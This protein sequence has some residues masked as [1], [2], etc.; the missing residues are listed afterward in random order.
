M[1]R[2]FNFFKKQT[3]D[4]KTG[5]IEF[6]VSN[7]GLYVYTTR[8]HI[9]VESRTRLWSD[10]GPNRNHIRPD[11]IDTLIE[12]LDKA[13]KVYNNNVHVYKEL[14][15]LELK[16]EL[17]TLQGYT[18]PEIVPPKLEAFYEDKIR[19]FV[20]VVKSGIEIYQTQ[21]MLL[22]PKSIEWLKEQF[23]DAKFAWEV[24]DEIYRKRR[25]K[26]INKELEELQS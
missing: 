20:K 18:Q 11:K 13:L 19:P 26:Q 25:I 15:C 9:V 22:P 1:N 3:D 8:E 7:H 10:D 5:L 21:P 23:V 6:F 24:N 14:K 12:S 4:S 2:L 16:Q 17:Y